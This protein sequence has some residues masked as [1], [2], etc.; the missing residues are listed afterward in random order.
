M[1]TIKEYRIK[2]EKTD[3][4]KVK[5]TGSNDLN[6]YVRHF[7]SDDIGIYE[8]FFILLLNKS[9]H[10]VGFAK[11]SQGGIVG[12]VVDVKIIYKYVVDSLASY[13][14]IC[15]NH[16]SGNIQPSEEDKNITQK[17]KVGLKEICDTKLLD[18]IIVT[19]DSYFSFADENLI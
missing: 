16:P 6:K 13:V 4:T 2:K 18:H 9:M 8:S 3:F 14:I 12:T 1:S 17:I 7:Y 11:I 5:I 19:E 15:H 10:T